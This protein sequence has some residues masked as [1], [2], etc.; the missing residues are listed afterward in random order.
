MSLPGRRRWAIAAGRVPLASTGDEPAFTS[1]DVL[2]LLNAG[3]VL[4]NVRMT[5]FYAA[6][7]E[8]GVYRLGVAPRRLRRVRINDLIFPEAVRLGEAYGLE[9]RSDVPVVVQFTRMDTRAAANAGLMAN[10]WGER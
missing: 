8:V 6:R 3:D 10:A 2:S 7:G 5:L 9:I 1:R 4:A